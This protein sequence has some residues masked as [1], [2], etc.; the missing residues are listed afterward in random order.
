MREYF[1][2]QYPPTF[3]ITQKRLAERVG[4]EP[5]YIR[6]AIENGDLDCVYDE[7]MARWVVLNGKTG[8]WVYQ[9][10]NGKKSLPSLDSEK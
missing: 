8:W 6:R 5:K 1:H 2:R 3:A 9:I 7:S 10:K 4:C